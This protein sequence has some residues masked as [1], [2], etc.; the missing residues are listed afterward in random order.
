MAEDRLLLLKMKKSPLF[1]MLDRDSIFFIEISN[2]FF[3]DVQDA[4]N[5]AH[6]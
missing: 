1:W 5:V 4:G 6:R 2:F 3:Q